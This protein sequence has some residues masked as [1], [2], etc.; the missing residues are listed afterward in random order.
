M[1]ILCHFRATLKEPYMQRIG[2]KR[3]KPSHFF[4][5]L[6]ETSILPLFSVL[7]QCLLYKAN[8]FWNFDWCN[9]GTSNDLKVLQSFSY[10]KRHRPNRVR[11]Y[12][13][14]F[15]AWKTY[16]FPLTHLGRERHC[17]LDSS[18]LNKTNKK[19]VTSS[20]TTNQT[21]KGH[22]KIHYHNY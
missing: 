3:H 1:I 10:R 16:H 22:S 8:N 5:M 4:S 6:L 20:T 18:V 9:L 2:M 17:D 11:C 21:R 15:P 19:F 13:F 14:P 12:K 7:F